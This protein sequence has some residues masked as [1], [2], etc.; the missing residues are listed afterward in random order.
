MVV[1]GN[2]VTSNRNDKTGLVLA[3]TKDGKRCRVYIYGSDGMDVWVPVSGVTVTV[4]GDDQCWK[5]GGSGIFYGGGAV[6]NGTY[7]GYSGPCYGCEGKGVQNNGD[8][9]R[10][11]GYHHRRAEVEE[12]VAAAERGEEVKPLSH[13]KVKQRKAARIK[14]VHGE[15]STTPATD[16]ANEPRLIDCECGFMHLDN[17]PCI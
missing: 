9:L 8:R 15:R 13:P 2:E 12:R 16:A 14:T 11:H 17:V 6:V 4:S 5:C 1:K 10:N 3:V 7:K